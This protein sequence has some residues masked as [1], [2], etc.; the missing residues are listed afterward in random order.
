MSLATEPFDLVLEGPLN[1]I[2]D[3]AESASVSEDYNRGGW[4]CSFEGTC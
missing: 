4:P 1:R 2:T 3:P